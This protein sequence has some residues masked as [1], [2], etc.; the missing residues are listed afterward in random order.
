MPEEQSEAAEAKRE[1][2]VKAP[3]AP[4][5]EVRVD[6]RPTSAE[7]VRSFPHESV[8]RLLLA[9]KIGIEKGAYDITQLKAIIPAFESVGGFI[10]AARQASAAAAKAAQENPQGEKT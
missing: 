2:P 5:N 3:A 6:S 7:A 4:V 9:V 8:E 1:E 10:V